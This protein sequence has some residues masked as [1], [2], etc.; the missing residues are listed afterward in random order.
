ME[1]AWAQVPREAVEPKGQVV[2]QQRL[3]RTIAPNAPNIQADDR[4]RL[5]LVVYGALAQGA[6]CD[7]RLRHP[8]AAHADAIAGSALVGSTFNDFSM[9]DK[10]TPQLGIQL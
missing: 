4:K 1:D 6:R 9:K 8:Q 10:L 3:G 2:L 5:D 7:A